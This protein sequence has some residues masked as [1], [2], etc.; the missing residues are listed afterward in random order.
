M[1]ANASTGR[2]PRRT[3]LRGMGSVIALPM[4]FSLPARLLA[5]TTAPATPFGCTPAGN[6]LR[7]GFIYHPNGVIHENWFPASAGALKQLPPTL[8]PLSELRE[9]V[10]V[11]SGLKHDNANGNGDGAGDHARA[12]A[13]FLTGAQARK[14][15]GEDIMAGTSI[16][17]VLAR[18][19]EGVTPLPSLELSCSSRRK[20]G[21]CDSGY[22]CAYQYNLSWRTPNSPNMP[23][24]NPR[25]AFER[26][27]GANNAQERHLVA[28]R[29]ARRQSVLDG[30]RD[31]TRR[32]YRQVSVD[33]RGKLEA[34][35]E[36]VR[37]VES[38][39]QTNLDAPRPPEDYD[40][41]VGVPPD[42]SAYLD[43][44]FD[45]LALAYST[46]STRVATLMLAHDGS[47][48]TFPE[49]DV[50][51]S[52]HQLSHHENDAEKIENLKRIDRFYMEAYSR[53]LTK[54]ANTPDGESSKLI[55]SCLLVYGGGI[56]DGNR[57][58]HDNLPV[59]L[60]G[61]GGGQIKG[62]QHV[63][64]ND[65]PMCNFYV[66]LARRFGVELDSFGDSTGQLKLA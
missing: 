19:M 45:L 27:F 51:G 24:V 13:T 44:M 42:H 35:L 28:Q 15:G 37:S 30:V 64:Y 8:E 20:T 41:P 61:S 10:Q 14:T 48:Q 23:E 39:I 56:S 7:V 43:A 5:N 18:K 47:D 40:A 3:F 38:R 6:P 16:D 53:F 36:A 34:Y 60:A 31:D 9:H 57:H 55:D 46:D 63:R 62:G 12:N 1:S 11:L 49:I 2:L 22:S 25:M 4:L 54:L 26:L 58:N 52:H 66:D 50:R 21:S 32:L 59:L 33:E 65:T 29:W 17:Q